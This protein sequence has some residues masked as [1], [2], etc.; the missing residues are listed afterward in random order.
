MGTEGRVDL[1]YTIFGMLEGTP[2]G[3][4]SSAANLRSITA[5]RPPAQQLAMDQE[6]QVM[7][8]NLLPPSYLV[9]HHELIDVGRD[10]L[11]NRPFVEALCESSIVGRD[12][13]AA[14]EAKKILK[15]LSSCEEQR[16][17]GKRK[18]KQRALVT[19][20]LKF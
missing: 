10:L 12:P 4:F 14:A 18:A 8:Y 3:P 13:A 17:S 20:V 9:K 15:L 7:L 16:T 2:D 6:W 5:L 11:A 19:A 1:A